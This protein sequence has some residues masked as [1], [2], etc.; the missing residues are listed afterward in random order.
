MRPT[1]LHRG[2]RQ[3]AQRTEIENT[4]ARALFFQRDLPTSHTPTHPW[5]RF[6]TRLVCA[7]SPIWPWRISLRRSVRCSELI[8]ILSRLAQPR[9]TVSLLITLPSMLSAPAP[10]LMLRCLTLTHRTLISSISVTSNLP[11]TALALSTQH[12]PHFLPPTPLLDRTILLNTST[13]LCI[14]LIFIFLPS[15]GLLNTYSLPARIGRIFQTATLLLHRRHYH[16][17]HIMA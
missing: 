1:P 11:S 16:P 12:T 6:T 5:C 8:T 13:Q 15:A 3:A 14:I 4:A 9:P 10:M 7:A 2:H 17:S